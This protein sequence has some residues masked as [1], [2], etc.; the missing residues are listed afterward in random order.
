M[1]A[2]SVRRTRDNSAT[3]QLSKL[4]MKEELRAKLERD[5]EERGCTL[6]AA[7][8]DRLERSFL[9]EAILAGPEALR[10]SAAFVLGGGRAAEKEGRPEWAASGQWR[11]DP[12]CY[13]SAILAVIKEAWRQH[14][15]PEGGWSFR[16]WISRMFGYIAGLRA[17]RNVTLTREDLTVSASL[18][19]LEAGRRDAETKRSREEAA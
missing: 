9:V 18:G 16:E 14:P 3:V 6:N 8:V 13:E 17:P 2:K 12:A 10:L 7:I 15:S 4:R 1:K 5:A 19:D 11:Q